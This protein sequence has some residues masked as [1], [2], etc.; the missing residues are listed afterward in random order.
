MI[1]E[2]EKQRSKTM[3]YSSI[4]PQ[5]GGLCCVLC[6]LFFLY[7]GVSG[8]TDL[9]VESGSFKANLINASPGIV[10][11]FIGC[12]LM[13]LSIP[14]QKTY[15]ETNGDLFKSSANISHGMLTNMKDK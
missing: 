3:L 12:V 10:L 11:I 4:I 15:L 7:I 8:T 2:L 6:G 9:L 13:F 5:I 1:L 14:K